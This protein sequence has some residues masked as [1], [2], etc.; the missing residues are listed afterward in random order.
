MYDVADIIKNVEQIYNSNTSFQVLKD[1]ERVLDEFNV[2]VYANWKD[3][4]IATGPIIERHWVKCSFMWPRDKMPDPDGAKTLLN[5]G[6]N[7]RYK[8]SEIIKPREIKTP[9]DIRPNTRKGKLDAHP[10][11]IVEI[12]MPKKLISDVWQGYQEQ[13]DLEFEIDSEKSSQAPSDVNQAQPADISADISADAMAE[14]VGG[15]VR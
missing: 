6:C 15:G 5:Y 4:E 11:W 14:P 10:I 7:I 8:K 2:Y 13:K 1:F 12:D 3:G 9:G